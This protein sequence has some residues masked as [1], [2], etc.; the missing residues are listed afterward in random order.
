MTIVDQYILD[1]RH[2][3][4]NGEMAAVIGVSEEFIAKR[5]Y[6]PWKQ[7]PTILVTAE[8]ELYAL[9]QFILQRKT[10]CLV[11]IAEQRIRDISKS[12]NR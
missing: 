8:E 11:D 2:E 10:G 1:H 6:S 9:V 3:M 12:L 5:K 4:T 7:T